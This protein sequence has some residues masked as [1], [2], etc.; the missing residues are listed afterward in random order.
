MRSFRREAIFGFGLLAVG[1]SGCLSDSEDHSVD[2]PMTT[3]GTGSRVAETTEGEVRTENKGSS[4]PQ[5]S[6]LPKVN[7]CTVEYGKIWTARETDVDENLTNEDV[8]QYEELSE[9]R[10]ELFDKMREG[11]YFSDLGDNKEVSG[12]FPEYVRYNGTYYR[13][14]NAGGWSGTPCPTVTPSD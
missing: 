4:T 7:G 11:S 10:K 3:E 1:C 14:S 2:S 13:T 12:L 6:P 5:N 9:E 8:V